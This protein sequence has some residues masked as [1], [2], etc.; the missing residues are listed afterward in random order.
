MKPA[1]GRRPSESE[2][3]WGPTSTKKR[4]TMTHDIRYALRTLLRTPGFTTIAIVTLAVGIAAN[5]AIFTVVNG[6]L[7][8]P[9]AFHEP[10]RLVKVWSA[11]N[12]EFRGSHSPG[13]FLDLKRDNRSLSAIAGYRNESIH[14]HGE[15]RRARTV[16]GRPRDG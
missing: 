10:E 13:D 16:A 14:H 2:W 6:V 4:K 11:T 3:G 12:T 1:G 9:L 7:L 5:T 15:P 8:R